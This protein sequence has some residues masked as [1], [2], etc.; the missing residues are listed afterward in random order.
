MESNHSTFSHWVLSHPVLFVCFG[1]GFCFFYFFHFVPQRQNPSQS[2]TQ[3]IWYSRI[4]SNRGFLVGWGFLWVCLGF[5]RMI[6]L[7]FIWGCDS[8]NHFRHKRDGVKDR[9]L[10]AA[11]TPASWMFTAQLLHLQWLNC[12]LDTVRGRIPREA[13]E[14]TLLLQNTH[15]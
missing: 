3:I 8:T 10:Q 2:E 15:S 14:Y 6:I 5:F 9:I 1:G 7:L 12:D 11:I 4:K 13:A